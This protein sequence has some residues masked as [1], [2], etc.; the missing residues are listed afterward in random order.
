M[1]WKYN[2]DPLLML[3]EG[4]RTDTNV[5]TIFSGRFYASEDNLCFVYVQ[6]LTILC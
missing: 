4:L 6:E 5:D 3:L 2:L 1:E